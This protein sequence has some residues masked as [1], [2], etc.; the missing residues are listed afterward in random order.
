MSYGAYLPRYRIR[1]EEIADVYKKDGERIKQGLGIV[2]KT[3]PGLDED[4]VT[5]AANAASQAWWRLKKYLNKKQSELFNY[6]G[7]VYVGSESHPYAV[8]STA[9]ILGEV[10]GLSNDYTAADIEFACRAGTS[11]I[12]MVV[13]LVDSGRIE[14]GIAVGADTAQGAPGD[15]LEYSS[16]CGGGALIVGKEKII[17]KLIHTS[18]FVS[19]TPDFWRR[20]HQQYPSHGGRFTGGPAYFRHVVTSTKKILKETDMKIEDFD[21][22]VFHMPNAKFPKTIARILKVTENQLKIG[23][24]VPNIGNTY[25]ACSILGLINVLDN[26]KSGEKILLT[27][28][29]SGAGADSFIFEVTK[30]IET[31]RKSIDS[32]EHD[33]NFSEQAENREYLS[34][35]Q[36]AR[37]TGK[38]G[39]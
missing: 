7:S 31:Y 22:V 17:A 11:G 16:A 8:K 29:G 38:M 23:L 30:N 20:E 21:H 10:L 32:I 28:Y 9:A 27:S 36:Y 19:D 14:A 13:G 26:A 35:G 5:I 24:I 18:S 34:Y 2:E 15:V 4:T 33:K 6:I 37:H 25:S 39:R 1:T 12:Q 3:V